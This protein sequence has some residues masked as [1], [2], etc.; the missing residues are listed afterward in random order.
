MQK[1]ALEIWEPEDMSTSHVI[2]SVF[3]RFICWAVLCLFVKKH[4]KEQMILR[5]VD[6]KNCL[7]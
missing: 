5:T 4:K 7:N 3:C 2:H 6:V 1:T